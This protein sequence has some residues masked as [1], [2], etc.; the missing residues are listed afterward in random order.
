MAKPVRGTGEQ[1]SI[2]RDTFTP[3]TLK[4]KLIFFHKWNI[5]MCHVI[6][7]AT[8]D[9]Y[10]Y[11]YFLFYEKRNILSKQ[12]YSVLIPLLMFSTENVV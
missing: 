5:V 8:L 3:E 10:F 9:I 6:R 1:R 2:V 4:G 11:F 12:G 7:H